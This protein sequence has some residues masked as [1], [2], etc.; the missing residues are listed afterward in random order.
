MILV[1]GVGIV[2]KAVI[3]YY[4][5]KNQEVCFF[6]DQ[7]KHLSDYPDVAFFDL[8]EQEQWNKIELVIAS[9]GFALQHDIIQEAIRRHISITN[10][11]GLFLAQKRRGLNIGI[12]GTNGKSTVCALLKYVL[13][14]RA[15]IGGNFGVSPLNFQD[16]DFYIIE[17]SS[18][19]LEL[20]EVEDLHD[21][22]IGV[23]VNIYPNH[24]IRH[25]SFEDYSAA[26]CRI[27]SAKNKFLGHC[28]LFQEPGWDLPKATI[29]SKLPAS[30]LF[31]KEEYQ[32]AWGLIELILDVLNIDKNEARE[33]AASYEA[34]PFR[35][36]II[37]NEPIVVINDSKSSNSIAVK[38]ALKSVKDAIVWIAGGIDHSDWFDFDEYKNKIQKAFIYG[39]TSQELI[40]MCMKTGI[41]YEVFNDLQ[42]L[43]PKALDFCIENKIDLLFSPGYASFDQFKN[44]EDRGTKFNHYVDIYFKNIGL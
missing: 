26:K 21:L 14:N 44:F 16:V 37:R 2:G 7:V 12:T 28:T 3:E 30:K 11:I 27:L 23:I 18:Y 33:K 40:D 13:G 34:L 29:A 20:L 1:L 10:D 35:Q 41:K 32:Y 4:L 17:L 15:E 39:T 43:I 22:E 5:N 19:Q 31:E 6:D 9:P 38:Q 36:Q 8:R 42:E 25:G 24:L